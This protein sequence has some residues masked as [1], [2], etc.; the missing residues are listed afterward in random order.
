MNE[1]N[2]EFETFEKDKSEIDMIKLECETLREQLEKEKKTS[3]DL[4]NKVSSHC[5]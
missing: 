1:K 5:N 2:R 4:S 3:K